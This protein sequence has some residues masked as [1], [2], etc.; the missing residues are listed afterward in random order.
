MNAD[1]VKMLA[2]IVSQWE[3]D[4]LQ[5]VYLENQLKEKNEALD[6]VQKTKSEVYGKKIEDLTAELSVAN[7]D[8]DSARRKL[9]HSIMLMNDIYMT[10]R[11]NSGRTK[12]NIDGIVE[13]LLEL[14]KKHEIVVI[15][16]GMAK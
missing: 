1:E 11:N 9:F 4:K 14:Q 2:G 13:K 5:I 16:G 6:N 7:Q 8:R 15:E 10:L 3:N 12:K